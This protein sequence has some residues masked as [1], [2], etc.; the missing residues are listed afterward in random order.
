MTQIRNAEMVRNQDG[1]LR[2]LY[3]PVHAWGDVMSMCAMIPGLKGMWTGAINIT[4]TLGLSDMSGDGQLSLGAVNSAEVGFDPVHPLTPYLSLPN[5]NHCFSRGGSLDTRL[6][7]TETVMMAAYRGVTMAAWVR[8]DEAAGTVNPYISHWK[9]STNDRGYVIRRNASGYIEFA[10]SS[11]G[12]NAGV[13]SVAGTTA[14]AVDTWTF[15]AGRFTP[16]TE[17]AVW[18]NGAKA[19]NTTSIPAAIYQAVCDFRLGVQADPAIGLVGR[20]GTPVWLAAAAVP[21][22]VIETFYQMSAPLYGHRL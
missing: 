14:P 10:I 18:T 21:D 12:T 13:F 17:L 5:G 9:E 7:G 1:D 15:T 6:S 16:S 20:M 19:V 2:R 11:D 3:S 22:I 8:F 4:P